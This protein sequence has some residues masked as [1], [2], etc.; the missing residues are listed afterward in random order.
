MIR[1]LLLA[2]LILCWLAPKIKK[3]A[4]LWPLGTPDSEWEYPE[5]LPGEEWR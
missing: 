5:M 2:A 1:N 4:L 3:W